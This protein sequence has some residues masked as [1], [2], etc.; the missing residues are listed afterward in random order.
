MYDQ[1]GFILGMQGW[2]D[3][4]K[5]INMINH[6][7]RIKDKNHMTILIDSEKVLVKIQHLFMIKSLN[8]LNIEGIYLK[9]KAIYDKPTAN[10][11]LNGERL[12][13]LPS[14]S[15]TRQECPLSPLLFNIVLKVLAREVNLIREKIGIQIGKKEVKL[16]SVFICR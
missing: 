10:I 13:A 1:V 12:K 3:I 7:N 6:I 16:S 9:I 15:G 2:F 4:C 5:S 14:A 11:I 8:K